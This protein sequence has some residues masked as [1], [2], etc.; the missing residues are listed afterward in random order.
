MASK[1][2]VKRYKQ[3]QL[4]YMLNTTF[5]Q[6]QKQ[7]YRN[8]T[9]SDERTAS[10]HPPIHDTHAYWNN[11][12]SNGTHPKTR[13][14]WITKE[15]QKTQTILT[16]PLVR[17]KRNNVTKALSNTANWK[18]PVQVEIKIISWKN[19]SQLINPLKGR[20]MKSWNP[21]AEHSD[22][23]TTRITNSYPNQLHRA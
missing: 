1:V 20:S 9:K 2:A 10:E 4:R 17:I 7:L 12:C 19:L 8:I 15:K 23:F 3:R 16:M 21:G 14:C 11:T 13:A 22:F 5:N 18:S 6:I